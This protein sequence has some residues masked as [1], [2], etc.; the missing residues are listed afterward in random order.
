[1]EFTIPVEVRQ[2]V[3]KYVR[4]LDQ[5]EVL[6]LLSALPDRDWS[7]NDVYNVVRSSPALVSERLESL[8]AAGMLARSGDP[9][10]YRYQPRSEELSR[11]ISAL[12]ATYQLSRH[13]IVELIYAPPESKD[14]LTDFSDAF[15]FKRKE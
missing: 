2:F 7:V 4:T 5:L 13:R 12:S 8:T 9:P 3:Q 6:L 1:M 14:P 15:K 10:V 11:A